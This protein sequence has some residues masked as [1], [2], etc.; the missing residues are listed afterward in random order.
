MCP[1]NDE[2]TFQNINKDCFFNA[3]KLW[4]RLDT[5]KDIVNADGGFI[6]LPM[7][8]NFKTV[9]AKDDASQAVVQL[10]TA[11]GAVIESFDGVTATVVPR[12]RFPPVKKCS[13]RY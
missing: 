13:N 12:T 10:E 11:M 3:N 5:L 8:K 9:D 7:I 6:P 1:D 2:T 4:I